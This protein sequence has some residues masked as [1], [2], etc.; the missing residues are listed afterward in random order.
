MAKTITIY[1]RNQCASCSMV[2]SWL[3]S[4]QVG[5]TEINLDEKPELTQYVIDLSGAMTVPVVV[6]GD[7]QA[8]DDEKE[9][10]VGWQPG[11]LM[12]AVQQ[13]MGQAA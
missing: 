4:K 1:S 10:I 6:I 13:L 7:E 12:P 11:R 3:Q 5:Y 8:G 2:K 9:V